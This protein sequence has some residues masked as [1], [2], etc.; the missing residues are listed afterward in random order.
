MARARRLPM[1]ELA[2]YLVAAPHPRSPRWRELA[3][4]PWPLD[5]STLF[6]NDRPVE[7][8]VG[9]GKGM[10]LVQAARARPTVNFLGIEIERPYVLLTA[11]RLSKQ[12]IPNVRLVCTDARWLLG[13]APADS[14]HAVHIYFPDPW[15]KKRHQ[16]RKLLTAEFAGQ[17]GRVLMPGGALYFV[18]DVPEY[19]NE[20]CELLARQKLLRRAEELGAPA[21]DE[22]GMTHFERKYRTEG[23]AIHRAR[24]VK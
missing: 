7:I 6:G 15:W 19:F 16:K 12:Q 13:G 2:P 9:F 18:T 5:W 22:A 21:G 3:Q 14:V 20:T 11:A 1:T 24:F 17:C 8:E 10:F 23:R 4:A